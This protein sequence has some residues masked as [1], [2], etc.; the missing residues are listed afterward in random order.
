MGE[1]RAE[2]LVENAVLSPEIIMPYLEDGPFGHCVYNGQNDVCDQQASG[3]GFICG[4]VN[5]V[6]RW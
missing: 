3:L 2:R 1:S 5:T 4:V 6:S